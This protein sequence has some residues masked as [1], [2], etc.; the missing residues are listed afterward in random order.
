MS[1]LADRFS[2]A[3]HKKYSNLA[4]S[5][6]MIVNCHFG[7]TCHGGDPYMVY[8]YVY[9][10]GV[11][12]WTCQPYTATDTDNPSEGCVS[13]TSVPDAMV[14][15]DCGWPPAEPHDDKGH[16]WPRK[17]DYKKYRVTEFGA[18]LGGAKAMKKEI[19]KRGS[20][21]CGIMVTDKFLEYTGGIY[22]EK[23]TYPTLNHELS[24]V[25][26][27]KDPQT[28]EEYWIGRNS[29][30]TYWGEYGFFRIKMHQDNL[31]IES[32]CVWAVPDLKNF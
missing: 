28:G 19:Y 17:A 21:G 23:S 5:P 18:V 22:S 31:G 11:P 12:D 14:C 15:K 3:D 1:A 30:G 26:Y 16:C 7:G 27:G 6:Q 2:I 25:G 10:Y 8:K 13:K 9:E 32:N 24:V 4:L 20:I 29:W